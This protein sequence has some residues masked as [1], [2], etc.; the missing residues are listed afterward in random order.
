M[1]ILVSN[2]DTIGDMVLRQ[3]LYAALL[4]DGHELMLIV[5]KSVAPLVPY[6]APG[7]KAV[8]LPIE[9]YRDDLPM[10]WGALAETF[11]TA[12]EFE[13]D[14]LVIAPYQ[15][16]LFEEKLAEELPGVRRI[17]MNGRLYRGNPHAGRSPESSLWFDTVASV[18][19]DQWEIEKNAALAQLAL[20]R[21][22]QLEWPK[23]LPTEASLAHAEDVLRTVSLEPER[24]WIAAVAGT[25]HVHLKQWNLQ[26]WG[27]LLAH[28]AATYGRRFFFVGLPEEHPIIESVRSSMGHW[29]A[30]GA[31]L[32]EDNS[33]IEQL[34][35]LT[36]LASGYIGHDTGPMHL[37]AALGKP[38]LAVFGGGTWPRFVPA[39]EPSCSI[40]VGVPCTGCGWVC[41]FRRPHCIEDVPVEQVQQGLDDLETG[42]IIGRELR[43]IPAGGALQEQMIRESAEIVRQQQRET[44]EVVRQLHEARATEQEQRRAAVEHEQYA[45]QI[46]E[47]GRAFDAHL[48][49]SEA[50]HASE[51]S[52]LTESFAAQFAATLEAERASHAKIVEQLA[53]RLGHVEG[54]LGAPRPAES[55]NWAVRI[56]RWIAGKSTYMPALGSRPLPKISLILTVKGVQPWL[57]E[58]IESVLAQGYPN[59]E[60]FLA[61]GG[62]GDGTPGILAEFAESI[63]Q[64]FSDDN[65]EMSELIASAFETATGE[66]IGYLVSASLEPGALLRVGEYFRDRPG[67]HVI[68]HKDTL[69]ADGWRFA[70]TVPPQPDVYEML[71]S[72]QPLT[73]GV[74]VRKSAYLAV[75]GIDRALKNAGIWCMFLR[76]TRMWGVGRAPGDIVSARGES[77]GAATGPCPSAAELDAA[78]KDFLSQFG[79]AGRI[80]CR[81]IQAFN[82]FRIRMPAIFIKRRLVWPTEFSG[83]PLP[84]GDAPPVVPDRP[85]STL[86]SRAPDRLLFSTRDTRFGNRR[87][88]YVY[89][90]SATGMAVAYPPLERHALRSLYDRQKSEAKKQV[91]QPDANYDSPFRNFRGGGLLS[92]NLS[93]IPS[94]WWWFHEISYDDPTVDEIVDTT[95]GSFASNDPTVRF[96]DVGC[97]EGELLDGLKRRTK[98]KLFGIESNAAAIEVARSKDYQVWHA[99]A[100][101]AAVTIPEGNSFHV[102]FL[103][104]AMEHW[105]DPLV[106]LNR[107]KLLLAP[108]G[109]IVIAVPNLDSKQVELF[110]PT[111]AHWNVPYHRTLL[112]RRALG[113]LAAMAGM[114]VERLCTRTHPYW[115]TMSVQL[116]RLGLGGVVPLGAEFPNDIAMH[117]TRLTGWSRL[118]WDW[119]GRGDFMTAVLRP[120]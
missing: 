100:E 26:R 116:N 93:R 36:S 64:V 103:G 72:R 13:P 40:M 49:H 31:V 39:V 62:S 74:F 104:R 19:E 27:E 23:L 83:K 35:A 92:E 109:A 67:G 43:V 96:L 117:G 75:G 46:L 69:T 76:L 86:T 8:L 114:R 17:G 52:K 81:L 99:A 88:H 10:H 20:G 110:G 97:F 18:T 79:L 61:D 4:R 54:R 68:Y 21:P 56:A 32:N 87:I 60:F 108:G 94:P 50:R 29:A 73:G 1:R 3:P 111:W 28:S 70:G 91:I 24:F 33:G 30:H 119:R 12:R 59:L 95:S 71:S 44:A 53:T 102:V 51:L 16:T 42:R 101:D 105:D 98:W 37:A 78:T 11:Q 120:H 25:R 90:E 106:G 55:V 89:Y 6:V 48:A 34:I 22:L 118:L 58:A 2:P 85:L 45:A 47:I 112:S 65:V 84:P 57:R 14:V 63:D 115:T 77:D 15:W 113:R 82:R 80:R 5:R 107:L 38:V 9:V 41:G 66:V 7:A